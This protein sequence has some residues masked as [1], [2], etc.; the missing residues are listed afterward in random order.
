M[1]SLSFI[2][3]LSVCSLMLLSACQSVPTE[4]T[5]PRMVHSWEEQQN[6]L[7]PLI[8]WKINGK[9]GIKTQEESHS[10]LINW[11]QQDNQYAIQ[12][13]TPLGTS[14]AHISG[15]GRTV[16]LALSKTENY[17]STSLDELL[18]DQLGWAL[19]AEH[20]FYWVRG[21]PAPASINHYEVDA[22]YRLT[23]LTQSG[24]SVAYLDYT[25]ANGYTLPKKM[26]LTHPD[27]KLTLIIN[28]WRIS[29]STL[30]AQ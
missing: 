15:D 21:L 20:L 29:D 30:S 3:V 5:T 13:S 17:H 25:L 14:V 6:I 7:A 11:S 26:T 4:Q 1:R 8:Y 18:W 27:L 28:E 9:L 2:T 12:V 16:A 23:T 19:P 24:W 22:Q 10:T